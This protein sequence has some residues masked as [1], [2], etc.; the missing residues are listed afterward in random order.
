MLNTL[1]FAIAFTVSMAAMNHPEVPKDWPVLQDFVGMPFNK[2]SEKATE[3]LQRFN[4]EN[5][6]YTTYTVFQQPHHV[7]NLMYIEQTARHGTLKFPNVTKLAFLESKMYQR[8]KHA[9]SNHLRSQRGTDPTSSLVELSSKLGPFHLIVDAGCSGDRDVMAGFASIVTTQN[10][11]ITNTDTALSIAEAEK[12]FLQAEIES[13]KEACNCNP[14]SAKCLEASQIRNEVMTLQNEIKGIQATQKS[15]KALANKAVSDGNAFEAANPNC[16]AYNALRVSICPTEL[17]ALIDATVATVSKLIKAVACQLI[18]AA[19]SVIGEAIDTA[20]VATFPAIKAVQ[21]QPFCVFYTGGFKNR[22]K[23]AELPTTQRAHHH[24]GHGATNNAAA[25]ATAEESPGAVAKAVSTTETINGGSVQAILGS[26]SWL[27]PLAAVGT[28]LMTGQ[29]QGTAFALFNLLVFSFKKLGAYFEDGEVGGWDDRFK[30]WADVMSAGG[31]VVDFLLT[32]MINGACAKFGTALVTMLNAV[33]NCNLCDGGVDC[34]GGCPTP[35]L[36]FREKCKDDGGDVDGAA[37][38]GSPWTAEITAGS[39]PLSGGND[40]TAT[41]LQ[42]CIGECDNDGQCAAGLECFQRQHGESIPGCSGSGYAGNW[43]YCYDPNIDNSQAVGEAAM[44]AADS[45]LYGTIKDQ[46]NNNIVSF[47]DLS[48]CQWGGQNLYCDKSFKE[49]ITGTHNLE[50]TMGTVPVLDEP[51]DWTSATNGY[52]NE[53][54]LDFISTDAMNFEGCKE[55]CLGNRQCNWVSF[56]PQLGCKL[57]ASCSVRAHLNTLTPLHRF[58]LAMRAFLHRFESFSTV[59]SWQTAQMT[60]RMCPSHAPVCISME[61]A[62][63]N[64]GEGHRRCEQ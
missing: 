1:V 56:H 37:D 53:N 29:V 34:R 3:V 50:S 43:D 32:M 10:N 17:C 31:T 23:D 46:D 15:A 60:T 38:D 61:E 24:A 58:E 57:F 52:C 54:P 9:T 22:G 12:V 51:N 18:A 26:E 8:T 42:A 59:L 63:Q 25:E 6:E 47:N 49:G 4:H 20:M 36:T 5:P 7:K 21:M 55:M 33:V 44:E 19:F 48:K 13:A 45:V 62:S 30:Q 27:F 14:G 28:N 11:I 39:I 64:G 2:I 35:S 40:R 41:N 16:A